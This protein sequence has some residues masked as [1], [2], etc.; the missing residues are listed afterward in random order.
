MLWAMNVSIALETVPEN[1]AQTVQKAV[2]KTAVQ[3][4]VYSIALAYLLGR[5]WVAQRGSANQE[6]V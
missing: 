6:R 5:A 2:A 4:V 1:M 3:A